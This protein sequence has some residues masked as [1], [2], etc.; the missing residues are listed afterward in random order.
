[1]ALWLLATFWSAVVTSVPPEALGVG[2]VLR[3]AEHDVFLQLLAT[4]GDCDP[5]VSAALLS[6]QQSVQGTGLSPEPCLF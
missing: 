2:A 3:C 5:E 1:M 4:R 6:R